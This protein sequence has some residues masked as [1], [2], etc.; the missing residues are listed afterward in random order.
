MPLLLTQPLLV[1]EKVCRFT[2]QAY[3]MAE[4]EGDTLTLLEITKIR[5]QSYLQCVRS[6]KDRL[7]LR[8]CPATPGCAWVCR[9]VT[10][11]P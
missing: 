9:S 2:A 1:Q 4:T 6:S 11:A 5:A 3:S 10:S 8:S 7:R